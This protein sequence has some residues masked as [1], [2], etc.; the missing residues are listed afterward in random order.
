MITAPDLH[1]CVWGETGERLLLIHGGNAED[2][3][4]LWEE[5]RV[6][7]AQYQLFIPHRRGYGLSPLRGPDWTYADDLADLLPLLG[8]G[9]HLVGLSVGGL[10][11]LLLAGQRPDLVRSLTVIE[12]PIFGLA[13]DHPEVARLITALT[14]VYEESPTEFQHLQ[15]VKPKG[16]ESDVA[17]KS[18]LLIFP[19]FVLSQAEGS[20]RAIAGRTSGCLHLQHLRGLLSTGHAER[21]REAASSPSLL[22]VA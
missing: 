12:P 8:A 21:A 22:N 7:V 16:V 18:D 17:Q 9:A 2:P 5:Q 20:G 15:R 14:L 19:V 11:A 6:L 3:D 13:S 10:L 1:I 4:V